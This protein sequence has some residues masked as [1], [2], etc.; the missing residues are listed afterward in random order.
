MSAGWQR[1]VQQLEAEIE[2]L[3]ELWRFELGYSFT[4]RHEI[5]RLRAALAEIMAIPSPTVT[6]AEWKDI[7]RRALEVEE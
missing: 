1:Q 2:R 4:C 5:D 6:P 3:R 7:A